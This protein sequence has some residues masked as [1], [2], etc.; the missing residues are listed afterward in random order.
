MRSRASLTVVAIAAVALSACGSGSSKAPS[1]QTSDQAPV[2]GRPADAADAPQSLGFPG[3]ATK[4]TT[5]VGGADPVADAAGVALAVYPSVSRDTRPLVVTIADAKDWRSAIS[6]AQLM[7][8]PLRAPVVLSSDGKVPDATKAALDRLKPLGAEKA[9]KAQAIR[10]GDAAAVPEGLNTTSLAGTDPAVLAAAVDRLQTAAAGKPS[11]AV[12]VAPSDGP[13]FAMPAAAYAAKAGVPILWTGRDALPAATKTAIR[14]H[15]KPAIYVLGPKTAVS[16]GVL[17]QLR[18]LGEVRRI[19][20]PDAVRLAVAFARFSDGSFGWNVVDPGHGVVFASTERPAD[21][22]AAA[23]L[24]GSGTYGPLMLVQ[25]A[26]ALP[27]P[28]ENYLLDIQPGYDRDPV[29][30]VYNHGWILGDE[31]AISIAV[32]A[33]IDALLEIQPVDRSG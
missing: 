1:D 13:G 4:N 30:G 5:R 32:Q 28:V 6:A 31:E 19:D 12:I 7:A 14:A 2:L 3:F 33:R 9:G 10:V 22:A 16:D 11:T 27:Q 23:A 18:P 26:R 25:D 20:A 17:D 8:P 29:R 15:R 24:S 21:A